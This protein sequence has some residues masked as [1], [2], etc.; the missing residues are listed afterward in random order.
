MEQDDGFGFGIGGL[1]EVIDV[2]IGAEAADDGGAWRCGEGV[3][4]VADGDFAV[5]ADA[6]AGLL[7]PDVRPPRTVGGGTK[8]GALLGQ[9]LLVGGVGCLAEFAMDFVLVGVRDELVEEVVGPGEFD[10]VI[11][12]QQGNEALLPVVVAAFDFAFGGGRGA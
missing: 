10:K 9:G 12:G 1:T 4:L 2:P 11:G 8:D 3:P 7:A 6:D 5:V